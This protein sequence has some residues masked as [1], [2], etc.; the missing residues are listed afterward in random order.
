MHRGFFRTSSATI[1]PALEG[2][3]LD[4]QSW[5]WIF[6]AVLPLSLTAAGLLLMDDSL[7]PVPG[8]RRPFDW[9]GFVLLG[10]ALFSAAYVLSQGSRWD[11]FEASRIMW[12]ISRLKRC[13]SPIFK[14]F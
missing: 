2:W 11:W 14:S 10:T 3:L 12:L 4:S 7:P 9:L 5:A 8:V 13:L 6:F 1:A